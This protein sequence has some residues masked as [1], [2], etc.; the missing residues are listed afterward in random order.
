MVEWASRRA[1]SHLARRSGQAE[2]DEMAMTLLSADRSLKVKDGEPLLLGYDV[3]DGEGERLG[4]VSDLIV[5]KDRM[6]IPFAVVDLEKANQRVLFPLW[7]ARIDAPGQRIICEGCDDERLAHLTPFE[8]DSLPEDL[9]FRWRATFIPSTPG[10]LATPELPE[11]RPGVE[12]AE[13]ARILQTGPRG[14]RVEKVDK[15]TLHN[16]DP[17]HDPTVPN[18]MNI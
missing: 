13:D 16:E 2:D 7:E 9:T 3:Y 6:K 8:G 15:V 1:A 11:G 5:D 12:I 18:V 14:V 17:P 4:R 10:D